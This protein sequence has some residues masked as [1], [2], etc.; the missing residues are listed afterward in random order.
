MRA[1]VILAAFIFKYWLAYR[2][3]TPRDIILLRIAA[4]AL[5]VLM[6]TIMGGCTDKARHEPAEFICSD[7][8]QRRPDWDY[9][10]CE[11]KQRDVRLGHSAPRG[12]IA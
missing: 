12:S 10:L 1:A 6:L 5:V 2:M 7:P 11:H 3:M 8:A 4:F 9:E